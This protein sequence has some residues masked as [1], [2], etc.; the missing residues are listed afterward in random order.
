MR[1][2][3]AILFLAAALLA[4]RLAHAAAGRDACTGFIQVAAGETTTLS[5]NGVWCLDHDIEVPSAA[6]Y[7]I[8]LAGNGITVDCRGHR[9]H[10]D[11]AGAGSIAIGSVG[12]VRDTVRN[13]RIDGFGIAISMDNG[14]GLVA[15]DNVL[16]GN[17]VGINL[18]G[19][20]SVVRRNR[21]YDSG[22]S[23]IR[24][25]DGDIDVLDNLVD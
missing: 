4:P 20:H 10:K 13:C 2:F 15:E 11:A 3:A 23:A 25:G 21:V 14:A 19:G 22:Y 9:I 16:R 18:Y 5:T 7:L 12:F 17:R 1:S 24:V 6:T 8:Q